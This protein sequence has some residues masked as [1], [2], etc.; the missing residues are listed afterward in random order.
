M[1]IH[2]RQMIRRARLS[3]TAVLLYANHPEVQSARTFLEQVPTA[4]LD[5]FGLAEDSDFALTR[6]LLWQ[7]HS[8]CFFVR[9]SE[10]E[11]VLA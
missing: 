6:R 2:L 3:R 1:I 8:S 9:N 4:D 10:E 11:N 5:I 7:S